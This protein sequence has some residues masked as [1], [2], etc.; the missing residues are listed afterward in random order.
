M[1]LMVRSL[2]VIVKNNNMDVSCCEK[3][4]GEHTS[5][6]MYIDNSQGIKIV[7]INDMEIYNRMTPTFYLIFR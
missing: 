6:F 1:I 7:G 5:S 4:D 3:M 2:F